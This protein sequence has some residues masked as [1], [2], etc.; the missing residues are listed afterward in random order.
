MTALSVDKGVL[1]CPQKEARARAV[2]AQEGERLWREALISMYPMVL[3]GTPTGGK[4]LRTARCAAP[5]QG[6]S[7]CRC[8]GTNTF[9]THQAA[10]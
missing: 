10:R 8:L 4:N 6:E 3:H 5:P 2:Y 9:I 1:S 7:I